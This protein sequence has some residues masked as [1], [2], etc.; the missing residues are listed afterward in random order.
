MCLSYLHQWASIC[1][2]LLLFGSSGTFSVMT[3]GTI[4]R[5]ARQQRLN[6]AHARLSLNHIFFFLLTTS[7]TFLLWLGCIYNGHSSPAEIPVVSFGLSHKLHCYQ[8]SERFRGLPVSA[9]RPAVTER[10]PADGA[11][12]K[13][14]RGGSNQTANDAAGE[15]VCE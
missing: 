8:H 12:A 3:S 1:E 15:T 14:E 7:N 5:H 4:N 11:P 6:T 13:P 10:R 9:V 2:P